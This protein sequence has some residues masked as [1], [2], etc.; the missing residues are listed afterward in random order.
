MLLGRIASPSSPVSAPAWAATFARAGARGRRRRAGGARGRQAG[1]RR[2]G[3][4]GARAARGRGADRHR[5]DEDCRRLV[6]TA[7]ASSG[8]STCWSTTPSRAASSRCSADI[9]LDE[10]RKVF[11]VNVF[12]ALQ[13]TQAVVPHMRQRG[14]GGSIIFINSMSMRIIEPRFASYASSKGALMIAAQSLARELGRTRSASTA[15]CPAT[16][17]ARRWR[18][19]S[20]RWPSSRAYTRRRLQADR[21]AHRA[22]PHPD[23]GRDRRRGGVLRLR[24]VP[25]RHRPIPRRQR[26]PPLPLT[27]LTWP[28]RSRRRPNPALRHS[29]RYRESVVI[30]ACR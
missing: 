29:S 7:I 14:G 2:G 20:S 17:G 6:D 9:D 19:T 26:R 11:D 5:P 30:A 8:A 28:R 22:Q 27:R 24:S 12:G 21:V 23:L 3:R 25:R 1:E 13:L 16:S 15:S 4:A 18:A 10:W